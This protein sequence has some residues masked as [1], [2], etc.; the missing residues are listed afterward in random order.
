MVGSGGAAS[1]IAAA[2]NQL[3]EVVDATTRLVRCAGVVDAVEQFT[4]FRALLA[5][6]DRTLPC[7]LLLHILL[8]WVLLCWVLLWY[9]LL[10][11]TS[12]ASSTR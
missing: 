6:L 3:R 7:F 4:G 11:S 10:C 12:H 1:V 5:A 2:S 8:L 9:L